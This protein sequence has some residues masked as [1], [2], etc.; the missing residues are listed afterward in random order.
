MTDNDIKRLLKSGDLR[1]WTVDG[2]CWLLTQTQDADVRRKISEIRTSAY[3]AEE[4]SA[5]IL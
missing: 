1:R 4:Y 2:L 5:G 3:H